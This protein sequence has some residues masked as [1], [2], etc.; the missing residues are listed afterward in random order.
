MVIWFCNKLSLQMCNQE[1]TL[2]AYSTLQDW[3]MAWKMNSVV[4]TLTKFSIFASLYYLLPLTYL[5]YCVSD[6]INPAI[7]L[8]YLKVRSFFSWR[9]NRVINLQH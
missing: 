6:T 7:F 1:Q 2:L 5:N 8:K 4:W 3:S 9:I